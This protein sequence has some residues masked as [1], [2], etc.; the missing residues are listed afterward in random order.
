MTPKEKATEL[1]IKYFEFVEALSVSNQLENA[2]QCALI[3]VDEIIFG[4]IP[5]FVHNNSIVLSN[6]PVTE[7]KGPFKRCNSSCIIKSGGSPSSVFA[8]K[9]LC[10]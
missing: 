8:L 9:K 5:F 10:A 7:P 6:K 3:A 2:K 1:F 4:P